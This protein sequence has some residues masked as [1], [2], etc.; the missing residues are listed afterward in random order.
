M[1]SMTHLSQA[2]HDALQRPGDVRGLRFRGSIDVKGLGE[3]QTYLIPGL[4]EG[5]DGGEGGA[6]GAAPAA[7]S[8]AA[9]D[10]LEQA[11]LS[12]VVLA[13]SHARA[14]RGS[15]LLHLSPEEA[16]AEAATAA[17]EVAALGVGTPAKPQH[18]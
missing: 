6:H 15:C 9:A 18:P 1:P 12:G 2:A 5:D 10:A 13:G 3:M 7:A 16:A 4:P 8:D 11:R 17:A 14:G